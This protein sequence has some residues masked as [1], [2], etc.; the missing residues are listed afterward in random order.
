MLNLVIVFSVKGCLSTA[1]NNLYSKSGKNEA[2]WSAN[3]PGEMEG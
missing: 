2:A 3:N 1:V